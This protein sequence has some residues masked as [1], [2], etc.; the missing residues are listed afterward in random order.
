VNQLRLP[1]TVLDHGHL[2]DQDPVR[3]DG[4]DRAVQR[5]RAAQRQARPPA[6]RCR[7]GTSATS[8]ADVKDCPDRDP[9][10]DE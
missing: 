6:V 9:G 3:A 1:A 4:A 5:E 8:A 2:G 10:E 7:S